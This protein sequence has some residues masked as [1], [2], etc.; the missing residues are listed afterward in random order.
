M[1][2]AIKEKTNA[3]IYCSF[4]LETKL[5]LRMRPILT[6]ALAMDAPNTA[7]E[8]VMMTWIQANVAWWGRGP[9]RYLVTGKNVRAAVST[10]VWKYLALHFFVLYLYFL[11]KS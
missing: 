10:W 11:P 2:K 5:K 3:I 7:F 1:G 8:R 6:T 9:Y 4:K